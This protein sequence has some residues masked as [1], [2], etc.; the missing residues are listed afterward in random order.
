MTGSTIVAASALLAALAATPAFAQEGAASDSA[1]VAAES[2]PADDAAAD[3]LPADSADG[4][5]DEE[6]GVPSLEGFRKIAILYRDMAPGVPGYE[7]AVEVHRGP[8][9]AQVLRFTTR[10]TPWAFV[11]RPSGGADSYTLRDFDCSGG[12]TEELEAGT[13]LVIPDCAM[14]EAPAPAPAPDDD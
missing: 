13:P 5:T 3:S 12:Y 4:E 7:T 11:V 9:G 14:P 2:L 8:E 6:H 10:A 1:A